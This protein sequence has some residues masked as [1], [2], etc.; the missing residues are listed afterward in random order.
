MSL[1]IFIIC[2]HVLLT[3]ACILVGRQTASPDVGDSS[4]PGFRWIGPH[5][6]CGKMF[7]LRRK[8]RDLKKKVS[9]YDT[10]VKG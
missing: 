8:R 4:L 2:K 5:T 1:N 6:L 9:T 10:Q 7:C 3:P